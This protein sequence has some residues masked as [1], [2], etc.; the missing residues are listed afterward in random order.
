MSELTAFIKAGGKFR[1]IGYRN[2]VS[3]PET[4][5]SCPPAWAWIGNNLSIIRPEPLAAY[6][7][8]GYI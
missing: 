3:Q 4:E 8:P 2:T 6:V 1:M 7:R 5:T